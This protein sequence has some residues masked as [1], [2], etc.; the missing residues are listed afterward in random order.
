MRKCEDCVYYDE[1]KTEQPCCGCVDFCNFEC[2]HPTEKGGELCKH[3]E[4]QEEN[5]NLE[6][7]LLGVM[8]FVDKWLDGAELE[9]DEVNR[10]ATMRE[11]TLQIMEKQQV[12]IER[13]RKEVNLV[14]IQ[15]QDLQE[16]YEEA[17]TEI[18]QW[19]EEANRY[20]RLWCMAIEDI[21]DIEGGE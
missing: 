10:A 19:K 6:Y 21:D 16:R 13:L 15:F 7:K 20:Q 17:Q 14:S 11:K 8:H 1:L 5:K 9:Q 18:A 12:E 4:R 2:N 3:F